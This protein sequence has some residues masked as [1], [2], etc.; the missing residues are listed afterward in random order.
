MTLQ[1]AWERYEDQSAHDEWFDN[2]EKLTHMRDLAH[3]VILDDLG[4]EHRGNGWAT[5]S[6]EA[7]LR[8]RYDRG[9]P[10]FLTTNLTADGLSARYG[11]P[12]ASFVNEA[13]FV[14]EDGA[15]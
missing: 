10:T 6:V 8:H 13:C 7:F 15:R 12:M 14:Y 1:R 4:K 9:R 11:E 3:L 2:D 5:G